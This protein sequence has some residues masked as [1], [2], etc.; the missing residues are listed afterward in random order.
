M[1]S[2]PAD[3]LPRPLPRRVLLAR[4][5]ETDW[6]RR[7]VWQGAADVPL[8]A[9]GRAQAEALAERLAR[10]RIDAIVAS[11]LVRARVTAETVAARLALSVHLDR[12]LR[13]ID[14]GA[15]EGLGADEIR[16]RHPEAFAALA[17]GEDIPRG[18]GETA[19]ALRARVARGF[20]AAAARAPGRT[21]L[22]VAHGGTLKALVAH[23]L[24]LPAGHEARVTSGRNVALTEF[25]C[26]DAG[27]QL[28]YLNDA[29][30]AEQVVEPVDSE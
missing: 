8:N 26:G 20:A 6:N 18:G 25:V 5:G 22:V 7:R 23:L 27:P 2:T 12:D 15:W 16:A 13:E 29:R 30:H 9:L 28:L 10:E 3:D 24:G 11:D 19:A 14:V 4:H 21:L 17:R 1:W